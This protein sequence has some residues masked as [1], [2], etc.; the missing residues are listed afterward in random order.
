M[1]ELRAMVVEVA[2]HLELLPQGE[3]V[4]E[5][6]T[7]GDRTTEPLGEHV[8]AAER[9]LGDHAGD[10]K[11]VCRPVA[12]GRVVVVAAAKRGSRAMTRR[13]ML[14]RRSA[15]P[16]TACTRRSARARGRDRDT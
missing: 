5:L 9:H 12:G 16:S 1:A 3:M 2:L 7:V 4:A 13:P 14:P 11:T 8:V 10:G 6:G 15:A